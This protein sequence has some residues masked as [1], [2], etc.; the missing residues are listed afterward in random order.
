MAEVFGIAGGAIGA[1]SLSIQLAESLQKIKGFYAA[2]KNA[3]TQVEELIEEI[4]IMQDILGDLE[5]E[6]QSAHMASSVSMRRCIKVAQRATKSFVAFS[7]QLQ[8]RMKKSKFRGGVK[9]ALSRGDIKEM[10]DQLERTKSSL[11]LAYSLYQQATAEDRHTAL[12]SVVSSSLDVAQG[13]VQNTGTITRSTSQVSRCSRL[14]GERLFHMTTPEW[15][16]NTIWQLEMR[17]SMAG[18]LWYRTLGCSCCR[19]LL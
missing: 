17:R 6:S 19:G 12:T 15:I 9:F 1:I 13:A 7:V 5:S 10:L 18:S 3:P 16:S 8:T 4:E 11:S 2:V 14:S